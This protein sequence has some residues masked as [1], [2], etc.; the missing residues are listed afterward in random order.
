MSSAK[1][2]CGRKRRVPG[3][4]VLIESTRMSPKD[5]IDQLRQEINHHD[6]LYYVLAKPEITDLEYDRNFQRLKELEAKHPEL[7]T[8]ESPTQRVSDRPMEGFR[9]VAHA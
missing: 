2:P 1:I 4:V 9:Q 7:V 6:Y 5:E 8:P 3:Q